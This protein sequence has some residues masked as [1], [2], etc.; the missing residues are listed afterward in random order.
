MAQAVAKTGA[1]NVRWN[2]GDL[3]ASPDDLRI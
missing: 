2:L 3:F 1:E